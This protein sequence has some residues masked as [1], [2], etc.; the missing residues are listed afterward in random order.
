MVS[1]DQTSALLSRTEGVVVGNNRL[2]G[3]CQQSLCHVSQFLLAQILVLRFALQITQDGRS[4]TRDIR[5]R[6]GGT[7]HDLITVRRVVP[8]RQNAAADT[9]DLRL[10]RQGRGGA[11][12]AEGRRL[13]AGGVVNRGHLREECDLLFLC[14]K[15]LLCRLFRQFFRLF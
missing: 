2:R 10:E 12:G 4:N 9:G 7:G 8:C 6:H 1:I 5:R 14:A 3:G 11:P 15:Q 13:P